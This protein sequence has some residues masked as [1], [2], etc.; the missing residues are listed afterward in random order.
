MA[1]GDITNPRYKHF[2]DKGPHP[3]RDM[4]IIR[5]THPGLEILFKGRHGSLKCVK[6]DNYC[7]LTFLTY[8]HVYFTINYSF[9][10]ILTA[11]S[12]YLKL[13]TTTIPQKLANE[14]TPKYINRPIPYL[15]CFLFLLM[16]A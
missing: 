7:F 1:T 15:A 10:H 5:F 6:C 12:L 8:W 4:D 16:I 3:Y 14:C 11:E 2:P 13:N 9:Q